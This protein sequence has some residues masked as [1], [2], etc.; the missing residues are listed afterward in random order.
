MKKSAEQMKAELI[1]ADML[2]Y[3]SA[4]KCL[5][6]I[7][8]LRTKREFAI[9]QR[10]TVAILL[11]TLYDFYEDFSDELMMALYDQYLEY[12]KSFEAG[13]EDIFKQMVAIDNKLGG[14]LLKERFFDIV[15]REGAE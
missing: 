5:F 6:K 4:E 9:A 10:V 7:R 14:D 8:D 12:F 3:D 1:V 2:K 15:K 11:C 13:K